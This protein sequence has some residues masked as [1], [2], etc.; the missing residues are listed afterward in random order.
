MI[1]VKNQGRRPAPVQMLMGSGPHSVCQVCG[2]QIH[3][4]LTVAKKKM[5]CE[6]DIKRGDG[7]MTLVTHDG[8]TVRKA[9]AQVSGY[10]SH[11]GYCVRGVSC[12]PDGMVMSPRGG[13]R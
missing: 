1:Q 3:F 9:P 10:E 6:V 11:W 8:R 5:P 7:R 2:K 4:V 13:E 12:R